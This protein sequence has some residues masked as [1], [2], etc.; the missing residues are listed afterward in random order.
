[1]DDCIAIYDDRIYHSQKMGNEKNSF[2]RVVGLPNR[3]ESDRVV[4]VLHHVLMIAYSRHSEF[5][6]FTVRSYAIIER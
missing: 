3:F 2:K 5:L 1:M 6:P 4:Q